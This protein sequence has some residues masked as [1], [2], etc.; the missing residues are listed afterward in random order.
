MF[1]SFKELPTPFPAAILEA[2]TS[3]ILLTVFGCV[4]TFVSHPLQESP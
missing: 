3:T 1:L 2:P 4:I